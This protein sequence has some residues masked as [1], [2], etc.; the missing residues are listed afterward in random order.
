MSND[1]YWDE[2]EFGFFETLE[3]EDKLL[4]LYDLMIG[5][6]VHEYVGSDIEDVFEIEF[7]EEPVEPMHQ[8]VTVS[9]DDSGNIVFAGSNVML[10]R[11]VA[12]DMIMNGL[13]LQNSQL[14]FEDDDTVKLTYELI[15]KLDAISPN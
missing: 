6:F 10:L 1:E 4:Y 7:E 2:S 8:N 9:F 14:S 12:T 11:K 13:I 5:D 3:D 15:G